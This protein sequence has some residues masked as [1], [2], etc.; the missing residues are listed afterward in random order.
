LTNGL[1]ARLLLVLVLLALCGTSVMLTWLV[2]PYDVLRF[3]SATLPVQSKFLHP[4]DTIVYHAVY[5]KL[6]DVTGTASAQLR[7]DMVMFYPEQTRTAAP[8]HYD[9]WVRSY[10]V[11]LNAPPGRYVLDINAE[12]R[13]NPLRSIIERYQTEPFEVIP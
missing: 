9:M 10:S 5:D 7:N 4:G 1:V 3:E 6:M 8:G 13:V 11:P 2:W 12:Y